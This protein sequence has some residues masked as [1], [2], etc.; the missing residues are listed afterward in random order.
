MTNILTRRTLLKGA[1]AAG[2]TALAAPAII[3]P[4]FAQSNELNIWSYSGFVTDA[5]RQR[6]EEETGIRL[7]IRPVSDQGEQFN[8]MAAEGS[9]F[10]ADIVC[11]AGHR[12]YQF[13]DA[14]FLEAIDMDKMTAWD[15][16]E[17]EY[18][19][20]NWVSRN[21]RQ[22]GVPLVVVST[23]LL[24]DS[25]QFEEPTSWDIMFDPANA[26]R[27]TYQ[28]QDF[29][30][31]VMNYL[32][33]DGSAVSYV[34]TPEKAQEAVNATRDF[35]I[36]HKS[37]VRRYYEA[38]N[39]IQQMFV[40]GDVTLGQAGSGPA[41]QLIIDGF[42]AGYTI[43]EEGGLAYAYGFNI[44]RNAA[45][46]DNAYAFLNALLSSPENGAEIVRSTGYSSVIAGTEELL[47]TEEREALALDSD[48][49][50]RL[51]WV[52]VETAPF[53][54]DLIDTAAEEIRAA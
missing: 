30:Q 5:F 29:F 35:L 20:A 18:S 12:F 39:E 54:F 42:P 1:G 45:N 13:V 40:N 16:I 50:S 33:Y 32:G 23:G 19:N 27:T 47:T 21:G 2:L 24:Y 14:G 46:M 31:I 3:R 17:S 7:N 15:R 22:W 48:E 41:A 28:I 8:L 9:N 6:F 52:D 4:A 25:S 44:T 43:P 51:S 26:G 11:V 38:P 34:G 36:E 49:R 10:S 37:Q 53:I